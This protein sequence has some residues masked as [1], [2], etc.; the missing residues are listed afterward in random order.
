MKFGARLSSTPINIM[1]IP[2][3]SQI[4]KVS[5]KN[6]IPIAIEN[7]GVRNIKM[8]SLLS[9]FRLSKSIHRMSA[10]AVVPKASTISEMVKLKLHV[11]DG[12]LSA[13]KET[14]KRRIAANAN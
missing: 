6:A 10:Q 13:K 9:A 4:P 3:V 14:E 7:T 8:L 11:I 12:E 2:N 5:L 1:M